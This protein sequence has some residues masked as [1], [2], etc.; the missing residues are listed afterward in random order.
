M[1]VEGCVRFFPSLNININYVKLIINCKST[2]YVEL[3]LPNIKRFALQPLNLV[4]RGF[5]FGIMHREWWL[6][7]VVGLCTVNKKREHGLEV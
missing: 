3:F 1:K 6:D 5:N 2:E 4:S 7:C